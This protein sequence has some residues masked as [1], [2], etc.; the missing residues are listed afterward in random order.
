[1][2]RVLI[3]C[4]II[5]LFFS[6]T[7]TLA[8]TNDE[9]TGEE[10]KDEEKA[11]EAIKD[12]EKIVARIGA[13]VI[14]QK[15]LNEKI[16]DLVSLTGHKIEDIPQEVLSANSKEILRKIVNDAVLELYIAENNIA[17]SPE[18]LNTRIKE[19]TENFESMEAFEKLINKQGLTMDSFKK[20]I[21]RELAINKIIKERGY[22]DPTE[23]EL[24]DFYD[25]NKERFK[26]KE[27]VKASHILVS[28]DKYGEEEA[29][30]RINEI[31]GKIKDPS[32]DFENIAKEYSDCPSKSKGGDLGF[33]ERGRMVKPFE[34]SAFSLEKGKVS[35][36]VKTK[37]GYHIIY[38]T[39]KRGEGVYDFGQKR[40]EILN[41]LKRGRIS[42]FVNELFT[43]L[44]EKYKVEILQ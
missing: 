4:M 26:H 25:S 2:Q 39:D 29:L 22:T 31:K 38:V 5:F 27:S 30:K 18:E 20:E 21:S 13:D 3:F 1:M 23:Q 32:K 44:Q 28:F 10:I 16:E 19:I 7:F 36:P 6:F 24:K 17:V 12:E 40:E 43:E 11:T 34:D 35:E 14:T 8:E 9:K 41:A 37:F 33:F 42:K 15:Q